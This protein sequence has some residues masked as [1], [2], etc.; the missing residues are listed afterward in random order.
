MNLK[1][2]KRNSYITSILFV[3]VGLSLVLFYL[4][5]DNEGSNI[6]SF[7]DALWYGLVTLTTVGYGDFFPVSGPGRIIGIF[8]ILGSLGILGYLIG[9]I[10]NYIGAYMEKRKTGFYGTDFVDHFV[11]IG[12]NN[13]TR[14]VADQIYFSGTKLAIVTNDR[15]KVP[16]IRNLYPGDTVFAFLNEYDNYDAYHKVNLEQSQSVFVDLEDDTAKL[17]FLLN[18]KK[19]YPQT[20]FIVSLDNA[21]LK[22]TFLSLGVTSALAKNDIASR[23]VASYIFEPD[24]ASYT[25]D[26]I[27]TSSK[28]GETDIFQ[29]LVNG[30]NPFNN[31]DYSEVF[32]QL[33]KDFNLVLIGLSRKSGDREERILIKNPEH[34]INIQSGDY[35]IMIGEQMTKKRLLKYIEGK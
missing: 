20:K 34:S 28:E 1:N 30:N 24:V 6:H 2:R 12:W 25:E 27:S 5:K 32:F 4:E 33:K 26:L 7:S 19:L 21:D 23:L 22:E 35:M 17:V 16:L 14:Q 18:L 31:R 15:E 29:V 8:F 10:S 3:Y 13:F 11:I 9:E